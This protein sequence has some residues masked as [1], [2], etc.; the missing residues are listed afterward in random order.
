MFNYLFF[1]ASLLAL[2]PLSANALEK[3][4]FNF[5]GDVPGQ[6]EIR[7]FDV[8]KSTP[9][10]L[11]ISTN[12]DGRMTT[13]TEFRRSIEAIGLKFQTNQSMEAAL[14]W[15]DPAIAGEGLV[16]F[17]FIIEGNKEVQVIDID[18]SNSRFWTSHATEF[19]LAFPR[20]SNV[21]LKELTFYNWNSFE[22][23][24]H[25]FVSFWTFDMFTSHSI[26]FMWGPWLTFNPIARAVMHY[27][28]PPIGHYGGWVWYILLCAVGLWC[29]WK[30]KHGRAALPF[31]FFS[32][33]G[34]WLLF[35]LRMG[36]ELLSYVR[37]DWRDFILAEHGERSLR[38]HLTFPDVVEES[39]PYLENEPYYIFLGPPG[40]TVFFSIMRYLTYPNLPIESGSRMQK[41]HMA[42][43][44]GRD[45]TQK[46]HGPLLVGA[47]T[48]RS[49]SG[50]VIKEINEFSSIIRFEE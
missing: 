49:G 21:I 36:A 23:L 24:W 26:N 15:K 42:L 18:L 39:F 33:L 29:L 12:K 43:I 16:N 44:F 50:S 48:V 37:N 27:K 22:K 40:E 25:G 14:V 19:G 20:G 11:Q 3:N 8:A 10:G 32:F 38:S 47:E 34:L 4:I 7:D 5:E 1:I 41:A 6:W 30:W 46:E 13:R 2:V 17:P 35:D 45:S 31:F 9:Q 28:D